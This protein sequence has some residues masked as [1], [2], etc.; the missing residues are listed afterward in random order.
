LR[1]LAPI[2]TILLTLSFGSFDAAAQAKKPPRPLKLK[3]Q[4]ADAVNLLWMIDQMSQWDPRTTSP[5]YRAYWDKKIGLTED[6]L[7][8]LGR[9]ARLRQRL[10]GADAAKAV[11]ALD[12]LGGEITTS[13]E[14]YFLTFLEMPSLANA[15]K[16]LEVDPKDKATI[17]A[18]LKHFGK[19]IG[20]QGDWKAETAHLKTF[21]TQANV[22]ASFASPTPSAFISDV[23]LFLGIETMPEQITVSALWAPPGSVDAR[24][25]I[26]GSHVILPLPVEALQNDEAVL[27]Q[28]AV[29]VGEATR[30]MVGKLTDTERRNISQRILGTSGL[31]NPDRPTL[32]LDALA[33]S[34]GQVL[35]LKQAFPDL[36]TG[37]TLAPFE[38][39]L[40]Y[41]YAVDELARALVPDLKTFLPTPGAFGG[42]FLEKALQKMDQLYPPRFRSL[43]TV[44]VVLADEAPAA[45]FKAT[46]RGAWQSVY[47]LKDVDGFVRYLK[48]ARRPSV[49]LITPKQAGQMNLAL[50]KLGLRGKQLPNLRKYRKKSV[51][52]PLKVGRGY[53]PLVIIVAQRSD[54]F[55]KAF[56]ELHRMKGLPTKPMIITNIGAK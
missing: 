34:F 12:L 47:A 9:Y 51:I 18:V 54:D 55:R 5:S 29:A 4:T 33:T 16:Y 1:T 37:L 24:P 19:K 23:R 45:L 35:F 32:L 15:L 21:E 42:G 6:D 44:A 3:F 31:V 22:L 49:I 20:T 26:V 2:L 40:P 27:R 50:K 7:D 43:A 17:V 28:M 36:A 8:M 46:F 39:G 48:D 56:V 14:K 53:G 13:S 25:A 11:G 38:P 52:Y 41:P 30:Y 10:G